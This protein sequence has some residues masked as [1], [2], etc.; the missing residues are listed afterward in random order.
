[1]G[2]WKKFR[3]TGVGT[4][5]GVTVTEAATTGRTKYVTGVQCSGD[6]AAIVTIESPAATVKW[7]KR[8]A[9]AFNFSERFDTPIEG[10]AGEAILAKISASTSNCEANM[11]GYTGRETIA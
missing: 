2:E 4:D 8:F 6:A 10:T 7:R 1:M 3:G 11:Q 9:G 5:S